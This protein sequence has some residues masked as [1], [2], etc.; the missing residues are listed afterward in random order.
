MG[1][2]CSKVGLLA[3]RYWGGGRTYAAGLRCLY[4]AEWAAIDRTEERWW[5]ATCKRARASRGEDGARKTEATPPIADDSRHG[6]TAVPAPAD[7][8]KQD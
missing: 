6:Q 1:R 2:R 5:S 3:E 4:G 8:Q 7:A